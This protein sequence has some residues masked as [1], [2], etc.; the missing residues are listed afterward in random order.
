[1]VLMHRSP[2][3]HRP[4]T[5]IQGAGGGAPSQQLQAFVP[6]FDLAN[7]APRA[8]TS[9][10]ISAQHASVDLLFHPPRPA[11]SKAAT[12]AATAASFDAAVAVSCDGGGGGIGGGTSNDGDTAGV[13]PSR[14]SLAAP[15]DSWSF[16]G[17]YAPGSEIRIDYG[18]KSNRQLMA[19]YGFVVP[20]NPFDARLLLLLPEGRSGDKRGGAAG[21]SAD[22]RQQLGGPHRLRREALAR[23]VA[24]VAAAV[25][26]AGA[27]SVWIRVSQCQRSG[28]ALSSAAATAAVT[29]RLQAVEA[30]VQ[31][32][33]GWRSVR[34][35]RCS[36]EKQLP[37]SPFCYGIFCPLSF[38]EQERAT[39]HRT[40]VSRFFKQLHLTLLPSCDTWYGAQEHARV[41]DDDGAG[42]RCYLRSGPARLGAPAA[43]CSPDVSPRRPPD[44][45]ASG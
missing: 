25:E 1:M 22:F 16:C 18:S 15:S 8:P 40:C 29:R 23:A 32:A 9:H 12:T 4:L 14:S 24:E 17:Y 33:C 6:F 44:V 27:G 39:A 26:Q 7:H 41:P 35:D 30:S 42:V 38:E 13:V 3:V 20:G 37:R 11:T 2:L 36:Q 5:N 45:S 21:G 19:Q 28:V 34:A 31:M 10:V 43:V